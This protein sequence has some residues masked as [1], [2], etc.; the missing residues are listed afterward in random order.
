[1]CDHKRCSDVFQRRRQQNLRN[2]IVSVWKDEVTTPYSS[3]NMS[4]KKKVKM[5]E[6]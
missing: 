3:I 4:R 2:K 6:F 1:M 5:F